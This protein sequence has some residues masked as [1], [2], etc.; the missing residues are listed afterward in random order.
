M[1][2]ME[3]KRNVIVCPHCGA[4]YLL[5]EIF[6]SDDILGNRHAIKDEKGKIVF[7]EGDNPELVSEYICDYCDKKFTTSLDIKMWSSFVEDLW[8]DEYSVE[9]FKDRIELEE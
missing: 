8:N 2:T 7:V 4:E 6:M 5:E 3:E 1:E 9:I